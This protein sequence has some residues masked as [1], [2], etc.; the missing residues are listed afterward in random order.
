MGRTNAQLG[1]AFAAGL[2]LAIASQA[3][4]KGENLVTIS[5]SASASVKAAFA[6]WRNGERFAGGKEKC[7]GVSLA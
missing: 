3:G 4:A 5:E 2:S 7:Y 1:A 6:K